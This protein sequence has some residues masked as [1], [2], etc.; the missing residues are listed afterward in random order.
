MFVCVYRQVSPVG[1]EVK[2]VWAAHREEFR[3]LSSLVSVPSS[4]STIR[5]LQQQRLSLH[6][7]DGNKVSEVR[8]KG[9]SKMVHYLWNIQAVCTAIAEGLV[10]HRG[11]SPDSRTFSQ[12]FAFSR[13]EDCTSLAALIH[14]CFEIASLSG[15]S[16]HL[17]CTQAVDTF[18]TSRKS[19]VKF[20][21]QIQASFHDFIWRA[22]DEDTSS[23]PRQNSTNRL[24]K[25]TTQATSSSSSSENMAATFTDWCTFVAEGCQLDICLHREKF[26]GHLEVVKALRYAWESCLGCVVLLARLSIVTQH[27]CI[28]RGLSNMQ[29]SFTPATYESTLFQS[30]LQILCQLEQT[31]YAITTII[32]LFIYIYI[33]SLIH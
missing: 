18:A 11:P 12:S 3:S 5:Q 31:R 14:T 6:E 16:D 17:S 30:Y 24:S 1:Q 13:C 29:S 7:S 9:G 21:V 22:R 26:V 33:L 28:L 25:H 32:T 10:R 4:S 2:D 23:Y 19:M 8:I 20:R 27:D 15:W